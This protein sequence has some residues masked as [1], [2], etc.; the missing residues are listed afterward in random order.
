[1]SVKWWNFK[2]YSFDYFFDF[3]HWVYN[4][5]SQ[6]FCVGVQLAVYTSPDHKIYILLRCHT[7]DKKQHKNSHIWLNV[8]TNA[9]FWSTQRWSA[10]WSYCTEVSEKSPAYITQTE[11]QSFRNRTASKGRKLTS[12]SCEWWHSSSSSWDK[13]AWPWSVV[14]WNITR[15]P[16]YSRESGNNKCITASV[17]LWSS[18]FGPGD[19]DC[20]GTLLWWSPMIYLFTFYSLSS[21]SIHTLHKGPIY[22]GLDSIKTQT[23]GTHTNIV[24]VVVKLCRISGV[25]ILSWWLVFVGVYFD[26]VYLVFLE[27][28]RSC[29]PPLQVCLNRIPGN[30][31]YWSSQNVSQSFFDNN[32]LIITLSTLKFGDVM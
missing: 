7:Q 2:V 28:V 15:C 24:F 3:F 25:F 23:L 14:L 4:D 10:Q 21:L 8:K 19:N 20:S 18:Y 26:L 22:Y 6:G 1:M 9:V 31:V 17:L 13:P 27:S 12:E 16:L 30:H 29:C 11:E 5:L 32:K